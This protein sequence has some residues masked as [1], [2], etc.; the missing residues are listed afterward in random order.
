[1]WINNDTW[2]TTTNNTNNCLWWSPTLL[3]CSKQ[4][5]VFP[6]E[7]CSNG[8]FMV[9]SIAVAD[10]GN[11]PTSS[12]TPVKND[13]SSNRSGNFSL[14]SLSGFL[15]ARF[16]S[17]PHASASLC[18]HCSNTLRQLQDTQENGAFPTSIYEH[19]VG[20]RRYSP[21]MDR[22]TSHCRTT[23]VYCSWSSNF[24][25]RSHSTLYFSFHSCRS[26]N[27]WLFN[28]C[29]M[30]RHQT[31]LSF[32]Q[33]WTIWVSPW[34]FQSLKVIVG[35]KLLGI[36]TIP[37][38]LLAILRRTGNRHARPLGTSHPKTWKKLTFMPH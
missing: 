29:F 15:F 14:H 17:L 35:Q 26:I 20:L 1:M 23:P 27:D 11:E 22:V 28:C 16:L 37:H 31:K 13:E 9:I 5:H 24:R 4:N 33:T 8:C 38:E 12:R 36:F 25:L 30:V 18:W 34:R 7:I 3:P 32:Q 2:E 6:I 10:T 21:S 19:F